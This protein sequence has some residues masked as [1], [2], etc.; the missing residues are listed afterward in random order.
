MQQEQEFIRLSTLLNVSALVTL[1]CW[2][3]FRYCCCVVSCD[4]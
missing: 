1:G 4:R 2:P 3:S